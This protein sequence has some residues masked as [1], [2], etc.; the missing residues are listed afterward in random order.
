MANSFYEGQHLVEL[1]G[2]QKFFFMTIKSLCQITDIRL[3]YVDEHYKTGPL[4]GGC[5]GLRGH[6]IGPVTDDFEYPMGD[7]EVQQALQTARWRFDET[8]VSGG[9]AISYLD[10]LQLVTSC[11]AFGV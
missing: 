2:R 6:I 4:K 8:S 5:I 3:H 10:Q 1:I 11:V 9:D 7:D